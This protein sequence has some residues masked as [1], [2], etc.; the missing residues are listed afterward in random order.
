MDTLK[1]TLDILR[2]KLLEDTD[3]REMYES[4]FSHISYEDIVTITI[5]ELY[6]FAVEK[7]MTPQELSVQGVKLFFA[8]VLQDAEDDDGA[9]INDH[10]V[11]EEDEEESLEEEGDYGKA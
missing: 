11:T 8:N 6:E 10:I 4:N 9:T 7:D 1:Q 3:I 5:V 2:T